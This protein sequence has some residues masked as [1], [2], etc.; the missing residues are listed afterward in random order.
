VAKTPVLPGSL[1]LALLLI[2]QTSAAGYAYQSETLNNPGSIVGEVTYEGALPQP[3]PL[4]VS[5]DR[6]VCGA[7]PIYDQS[8]VVGKNDGIANVVVTLPDIEKGVPMS[9]ATDVIFDQIGCEYNPHVVAFPAGST[10][11][12]INSDGIL[13]NIHTDSTVNPVIDMAQPGFKK[14]I[15]LKIAKPEAI[16]VTCDAHN[17]MVGWWYVTG[18]PY[19]AVTGPDGHFRIDNIPAGTYKVQAWQEK[20]GV[21]T[22]SVTIKPGAAATVDFTMGG[23]AH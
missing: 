13:H 14:R 11:D 5:K 7:H 4:D 12:V 8:L 2:V 3:A 9:P 17:W 20:L 18:N 15:K 22:R 16:Q 1:F 21:Q 10:V 19:Y 23:K 6:A